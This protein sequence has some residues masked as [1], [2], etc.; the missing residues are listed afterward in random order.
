VNKTA[1]TATPLAKYILLHASASTT[2][3][4]RCARTNKNFILLT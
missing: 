1:A 3:A 4:A 2:V